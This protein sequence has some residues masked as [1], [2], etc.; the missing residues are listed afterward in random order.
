MTNLNANQSPAELRAAV[1]AQF[2]QQRAEL[3][4]ALYAIEDGRMSGGWIVRSAANIA[5]TFTITPNGRVTD[6]KMAGGPHKAH[7]FTARDARRVAA[8]VVDGAGAAGNHV[9]VKQAVQ[10][11]IDNLTKI[12]QQLEAIQAAQGDVK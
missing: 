5:L 12:I 11:E 2:D 1:I 8:D 6:P 10:D 3:R 7:R 4:E 9:H